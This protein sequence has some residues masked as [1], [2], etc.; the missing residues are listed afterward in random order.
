MLNQ[1]NIDRILDLSPY[2]D[3]RKEAYH[4]IQDRIPPLNDHSLEYRYIIDNYINSCVAD[5]RQ[6]NSSSEFYREFDRFFTD[7]E[8]RRKIGLPLP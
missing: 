2:E 1:P 5:L 3:V 8:Y 7:Q 6:N 4:F